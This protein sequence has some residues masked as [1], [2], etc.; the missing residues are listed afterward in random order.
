MDLG[1]TDAV[2]TAGKVKITRDLRSRPDRS[3]RRLDEPYRLF[4][5]G[6]TMTMLNGT[7]IN[8]RRAY[9]ACV[10]G[11]G[12]EGGCD[13]SSFN[14]ETYPDAFVRKIA[15]DM[16]DRIPESGSTS[17]TG[18]TGSTGSSDRQPWFL[19]VNFPGP[20]HPIISTANMAKSVM[21]RTWPPPFDVDEPEPG[22]WSLASCP[23]QQLLVGRNDD[24]DV[25][26]QVGGRC[27][28]GAEIEYIDEL[29][30]T[31]VD[32]VEAMG[33]LDNTIVVV[34]SDHGD[35][36]SDHGSTGKGKP[37]RGSVSV[38][39]FVSGPGIRAGAVHEGPVTTLDLGGTFL[40]F[41]G[42]DELA[43]GMTTAS[44]RSILEQDG[45]GDEGTVVAAPETEIAEGDGASSTTT[46]RGISRSRS[47]VSSG[48]GTW[49][50]VVKEM[51]TSPVDPTP[52]SYKL[53]CCKAEQCPG[54]PRT[55]TP[56]VEGEPWHILLY[57]AVRDPFDMEPLDVKRPD[58]VQELLPL[59]PEGWCRAWQ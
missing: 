51:P 33:E 15:I 32:K 31:I 18:S 12:P 5:E 2:R 45:D 21:D 25:G 56:Y 11:L 39:L 8:A 36:L 34:T 23:Q 53:I 47:H 6:T 24:A 29:M 4:L 20:H 35:D 59:L 7:D 26:P 30:Q 38:P 58:I 10:R 44:L 13:S 46:S 40:D 9:V 43:P 52:T 19:Q 27:N 14:E 17:S 50:M 48:Y 37:W 42:V 49:R 55:A 16:L 1:F 3:D 41:A 22:R 54:A 28:Y 57:D